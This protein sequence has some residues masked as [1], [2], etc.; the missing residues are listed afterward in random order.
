VFLSG[1]RMVWSA[2]AA[3]EA[4]SCAL[5]LRSGGQLYFAAKRA[6]TQI[7]NVQVPQSNIAAKAFRGRDG[8]SVGRPGLP[9]ALIIYGLPVSLSLLCAGTNGI[10][11]APLIIAIDRHKPEGLQ[12]VGD[13]N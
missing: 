4:E 7:T 9:G 2:N 13:R 1:Q 12:R 10:P 3:S 5:N 8:L 6:R 11:D